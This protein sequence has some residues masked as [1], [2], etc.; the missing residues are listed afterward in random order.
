[1]TITTLIL[2]FIGLIGMSV[3]I[4]R[5]LPVLAELSSTEERKPFFLKRFM[6]RTRSGFKGR[7]KRKEKKDLVFKTEDEPDKFSDDYW[8]KVRR[9]G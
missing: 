6:G 2:F 1:M 3:I 5:K 7:F 9:K 8:R 4:I